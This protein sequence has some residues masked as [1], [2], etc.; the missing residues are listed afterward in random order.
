MPSRR[1]YSLFIIGSFSVIWLTPQAGAVRQVEGRS[2][3]NL[4]PVVHHL[5]GGGQHFF[6]FDGP[7]E[8]AH[9]FAG[10]IDGTLTRVAQHQD[11][12]SGH[13]SMQLGHK[14]RPAD[15]VRVVAGDDQA[16]IPGKLRL[17]D[18]TESLGG[19]RNTPHIGE[20]PFQNGL[21]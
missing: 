11:G 5:A 4:D 9:A 10:I 18:E 16:K 6:S 17:L 3:W 12:Q 8:E 13:A 2:G 1:G 21:T 14:G 7:G 20:S 19:I 15:A